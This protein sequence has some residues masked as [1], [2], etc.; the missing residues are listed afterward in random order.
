M[1]RMHN[2][3]RPRMRTCSTYR[4]LPMKAFFDAKSQTFTYSDFHMVLFTFDGPKKE[5]SQA[6]KWKTEAH[7]DEIRQKAKPKTFSFS[8]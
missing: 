5:A 1:S 7:F 8:M 2:Q 4:R 6:F 3:R